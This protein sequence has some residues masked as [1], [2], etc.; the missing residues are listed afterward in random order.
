VRRVF[1]YL[2]V[3]M[4][5]IVSVAVPRIALAAAITPEN[6]G[7]VVELKQ[8]GKPVVNGAT[9]SPDGRLVAVATSLAVELRD[10]AKLNTVVRTLEGGVAFRSVAFSPDGQLIAGGG[11]YGDVMLWQTAD[12]KFVRKFEQRAQ[13][14]VRQLVFSPDGKLLTAQVSDFGGVMIVWDVAT[15]KVKSQSDPLLFNQW[16]VSP[17]GQK[18][19]ATVDP[20][21]QIMIFSLK[22]EPLD[23]PSVG[24]ENTYV[25]AFSPDGRLLAS[26][27]EDGK[28]KLWFVNGDGRLREF[29]EISTIVSL[30]FSPDS[31]LLA[32]VSIINEVAV[33]DTRSGRQLLY[34]QG[35]GG[36]SQV[37][38]SLSFSG[39]NKLLLANPATGLR[40]WQV[41]GGR[42]LGSLALSQINIPSRVAFGRDGETVVSGFP[43]NQAQVQRVA[44]GRS[45]ARLSNNACCYST[46]FLNGIY[47]LSSVPVA[48]GPQQRL[49]AL[50]SSDNRN[51]E[52]DKD[53]SLITIQDIRRQTRASFKLQDRIFS[54]AFSPDEQL[55]AAGGKQVY[56]VNTR[57]RR[58]VQTLEHA[59]D[60]VSSLAF[61]SDGQLLAAASLDGVIR[62]WQVANG[63]LVREL[64]KQEKA[65]LAIAFSPDNA[66][67]ATAGADQTVRLWRVADG[68]P[69]QTLKGHESIV[70]TVAFSA[71]GALLASGALDGA[72]N[73]WQVSDGKLLKTL[74]GHTDN[75]LGVAFMKDGRLASASSDGTTRLWGVK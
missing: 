73:L 12:G 31:R 4:C 43:P 47:P 54:L 29:G 63:R 28:V 33:W 36:T 67:L 49:L 65:I 1:A 51:F 46:L 20:D 16:V 14:E 48:L 38:V 66:L 22:V 53:A 3:T 60:S 21:D 18:L 69:A 50:S 41:P 11:K 74:K 62:L 6:A 2:A 32:A 10:A 45:V 71:D 70:G 64:P 34:V 27:A 8:I 5:V 9:I 61:S 25:M 17:D 35:T 44:D 59:K 30:S 19:A 56:L 40:L 24:T 42:Q 55:L 23:S 37:K 75:V 72:I 58:I 52:S 13:G 26:S 57:D 15:G 39:D 68:K 7:Q